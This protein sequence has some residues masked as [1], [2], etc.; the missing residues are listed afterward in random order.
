MAPED[1]ESSSDAHPILAQPISAVAPVSSDLEDP[2]K[3]CLNISSDG[4]DTPMHP[5]GDDTRDLVALMKTPAKTGEST[6]GATESLALTEGAK[7]PQVPPAKRARK[8]ATAKGIAISDNPPT[9]PLD[10]PFTQEML[11]V[12]IRYIGLEKEVK[13][14]RSAYSIARKRADDLESTLESAEKALEEEKSKARDEEKKLTDERSK[15]VLEEEKLGE[16]KSKMAARDED[17]RQHLDALNTSL[18]K[19]T[20]ADLGLDE[21][22]PE[23]PVLGELAA[24]EGNIIEVRSL[25]SHSWRTFLHLHGHFFPTKPLSADVSFLNLV[26]I[27]S[28]DPNPTS[29]FRW[30]ITKSGIEVTMAMAIAHGENVD[31]GMVSSSFAKDEAGKVKPLKSFY[32]EA[33]KYSKVFLATT[34]PTSSPAK[35]ALALQPS[36]SAT[37]SEVP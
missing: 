3:A 22:A 7:S 10:H 24:V 4:D 35:G 33:K 15:L 9:A 21:N 27:F 30:S 37:A 19:R 2:F 28:A 29:E 20:G 25:L 34:Q 5:S 36:A 32:K 23:D 1:S 26:K 31:W 12:A 16:E 18:I 17:I 13:D 14:L 11:G 8:E 6:E